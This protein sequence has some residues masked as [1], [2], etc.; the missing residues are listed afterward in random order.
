[1]Y[2][3]PKQNS[4]PT[5]SDM[6]GL[7]FCIIFTTSIP[8]DPYYSSMEKRCPS[9]ACSF[10]AGRS[11]LARHRF[12]VRDQAFS[13]SCAERE[14]VQSHTAFRRTSPHENPINRKGGIFHCGRVQAVGKNS[15]LQVF[16]LEAPVPNQLS[17]EIRS[18]M[19]RRCWV[20]GSGWN[21]ARVTSY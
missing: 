6:V 5:I 11:E 14:Q 19:P 12:A 21:R 8:V 16:D 10:D 9:S 4:T 17:F 2:P 7:I 13:E 3:T 20:Y 18:K 1:M 15:G